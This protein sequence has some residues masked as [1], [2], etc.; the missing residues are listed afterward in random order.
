MGLCGD[1]DFPVFGTGLVLL[2][3]RNGLDIEDEEAK[4]EASDN[5]VVAL[6]HSL[7]SHRDFRVEVALFL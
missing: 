3:R 7:L 4:E 1:D 2:A 5:D 6:Q